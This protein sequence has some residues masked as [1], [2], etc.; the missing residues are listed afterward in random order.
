MHLRALLSAAFL[1]LAASI[2]AT[3]AT[4]DQQLDGYKPVDISS[5]QPRTAPSAMALVEPL[6][7]GHPEASEG[8]PTLK[9]DLRPDEDGNGV[10]I[11]IEMRGYLDDSVSGEQYRALITWTEDG[12]TLKA[13]GVRY[14]CARGST[15]GTPTTTLCP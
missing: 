10:I 3:S 8:R 4:S 15:A 13:L 9:I 5:W 14:I 2:T 6:Y 1:L 11:D 7:R 12:W